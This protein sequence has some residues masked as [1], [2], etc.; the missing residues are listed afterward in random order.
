MVGDVDKSFGKTTIPAPTT[1]NNNIE[2]FACYFRLCSAGIKHIKRIIRIWYDLT[3]SWRQ[4]N[5]L[6]LISSAPLDAVH[7]KLSTSIPHW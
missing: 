4:H 1:H 7:R 5:A 6:N 3:F 2:L